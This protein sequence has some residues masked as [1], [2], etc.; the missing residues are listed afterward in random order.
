MRAFEWRIFKLLRQRIESETR[1]IGLNAFLHRMGKVDSPTCP[2]CLATETA[3]FS[4]PN[5]R[6]F[7]GYAGQ[8]GPRRPLNKP[9]ATDASPKRPPSSCSALDGCLT[10]S[11]HPRSTTTPALTSTNRLSLSLGRTWTGTVTHGA[12]RKPCQEGVTRGSR[13]ARDSLRLIAL[14]TPHFCPADPTLLPSGP[15]PGCGR[16][17]PPL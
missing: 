9:W 7:G 3:H 6:I 8:T 13:R 10:F 11:R 2:N 5:T 15:P 14:R 1:H 12:R 4:A 16:R 17:A